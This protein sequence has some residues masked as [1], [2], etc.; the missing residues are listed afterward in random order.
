MH[1]LWMCY[2]TYPDAFA[3][4]YVKWNSVPFSVWASIGKNDNHFVL[5]SHQLD[6]VLQSKI[7]SL[8][9]VCGL[10]QPL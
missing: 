5:L 4:E 2:G 1:M 7:K 3:A 10:S 9:G 8:S 6:R